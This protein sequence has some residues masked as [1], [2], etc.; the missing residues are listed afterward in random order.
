MFASYAVTDDPNV[1]G[2]GATAIGEAVTGTIGNI[3]KS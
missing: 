3:E 2:E 1:D